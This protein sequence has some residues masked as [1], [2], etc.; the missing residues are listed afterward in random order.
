MRSDGELNEA[1]TQ[2][3]PALREEFEALLRDLVQIPTVSMDP[4]HAEDVRRG[5]RRAAEILQAC[6]AQA[7]VVDTPGYPVVFGQL[8]G[9]PAWPTVAIYN[10]LDVQPAEEPEWRFAP[11][12]FHRDGDRYL[13]RGTTDD[14]GPALTALLAARF[15]HQQG[16]PL[17]VQFLWELEEE[18]GSP[19]FAH[20]VRARRAALTCQSVLVSDTVWL[21]RTRPAVPYGLR[22]LLALTLRLQTAAKDCHSGLTGGAARNPVGELAQLI[23]QCYDARSGR[24]KIKGF[25]D[26]VRRL[27]RAELANFLASGFSLAA[28]K[29]AHGL[30]RLRTRSV[31]ETVQALWSRPTF[32]VHGIS[33]GYH[34]PG[35]KTIVP[36]AAEAKLSMRLVPDQDPERIFALVRDFVRQCHPEVEVRQAGALRPYLGSF[37][38]FYAEAVRA[39]LRFGF[40]RSPA[41]I[42]EGGSIG[43]VVTLAE[44][45]RVPVVFLGLSLP[46]HGY[47]APNEYFDWGQASGGL[48]AFVKY[49]ALLAERGTAVPRRSPTP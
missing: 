17:N 45:L 19:H 38:G 10:H 16:I 43:A 12:A 41:F 33:G 37:E 6:G 22:G 30:Y 24:V 39:A 35:V 1:L 42:R 14:K 11:F 13:G 32:E 9:D 48:K 23:T 3:L 34:G 15:A 20:F 5:A 36:A 21:S 46:E 18:I 28:F 7:E 25:Y 44:E 49:F 31:A 8:Q 2:A 47:H 40:G 27:R 29:R 4:A 26:D